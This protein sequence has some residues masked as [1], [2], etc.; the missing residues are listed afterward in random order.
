LNNVNEL[1]KKKISE[2]ENNMN[3]VYMSE[4]S[5]G[6]QLL[7]LDEAK[8]AIERLILLLKNTEEYKKFGNFADDFKEIH[9]LKNITKRL[10]SNSLNQQFERK[11]ACSC[12]E[13]KI[14]ERMVWTP[15]ACYKIML[16]MKLKYQE[17]N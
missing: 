3:E 5:K 10:K 6:A 12:C 2:M 16:E 1:F 17:M 14:D 11:R 9:Y 8:Q 4:E 15:G 7:E 13:V